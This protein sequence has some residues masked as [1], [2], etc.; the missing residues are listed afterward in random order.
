MI[1]GKV[2]EHDK[3]RKVSE[4]N[5]DGFKKI[6]QGR[7]KIGVKKVKDQEVL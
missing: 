7:E 6:L 4:T 1:L 2:G 3:G 5:I